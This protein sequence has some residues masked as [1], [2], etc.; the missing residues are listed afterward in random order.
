MLQE[1][2]AT[3][4]LVLAFMDYSQAGCLTEVGDAFKTSLAAKPLPDL[5]G[6]KNLS[7]F[8]PLVAL[9]EDNS[10]EIAAIIASWRPGCSFHQSAQSFMA[11]LV[12]S[13]S[14]DRVT[15]GGDA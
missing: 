9:T 4:E 14:L 3:K 2:K 8:L 5:K 13:L 12:L 6:S 7:C 10:S 1:E 11:R 15:G